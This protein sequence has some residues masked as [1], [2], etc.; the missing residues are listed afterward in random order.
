MLNKKK[1]HPKEKSKLH[2]RNKNRSRYDFKKLVETC[3]ELAPFVILNKYEDESIDFAN[4]DAIKMLN[5]SLLMHFYGLD[6]WDIPENYL[7]PPIPGRADY[8]HHIADLLCQNNYGKIPMGNKFTCIDIGVGANCIYPIIGNNEYGWSF[9][10]SDIDPLAIASAEKIIASNPSLK[11]NVKCVLQENSKDYF[12][13]VIPKDELVDLSICNPPFHASAKDAL[14]GSMR[15]TRN[16]SS[17]KVTKPSLNFAGQSNELWCDGGEERFVRNM[18][19][20]S[21]KFAKSCFWFSTLIS[22]ESNLKSV[23][24]AL[25]EVNATKIET[26]P[27]GQGNKISRIVAWTFL[28]KEEQ[29]R[30]KNVRWNN[31]PEKKK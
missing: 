4:P 27:M 16:L 26:L 18:I 8:I 15:K 20:Q 21:K 29:Q 17:E 22:K 14:E 11:G 19:N 28:S 24:Q 12:Y 30:W 1:E 23:Y 5:K 6:H 3:P 31:Q 25:T 13:G 9:I 2:P 7:C 10:G